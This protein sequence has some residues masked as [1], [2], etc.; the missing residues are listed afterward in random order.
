MASL[1][2][3][4]ILHAGEV[5]ARHRRHF[6]KGEQIE[7]AEHIDELVKRKRQAR[8]QRGQDQL[9]QAAPSS[10]ILLSR[11]VERGNRLST[12]VSS[13]LTLLDTYGA[14]ELEG[15]IQEALHQDT[16]HPNAVHLALQRRREQRQLP[17]PIPVAVPDHPKAK[18]LVV[19]SASLAAYDQLSQTDAFKQ[20]NSAEATSL[21]STKKGVQSNESD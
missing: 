12:L 9:S 21:T 13:L 5:V 15:A 19:R 10:Q 20:I 4:R 8:R 14:T 7:Q 16:P 11:A 6:G 3:V 18:K 17:P 1:T 2:E